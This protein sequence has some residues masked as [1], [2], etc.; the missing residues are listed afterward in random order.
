[1]R[2]RTFGILVSAALAGSIAI[3]GPAVASQQTISTKPVD[4]A[5]VGLI[6]HFKP[7]FSAN[8]W[9]GQL[10][11]QEALSAAG[12]P[13]GS[14]RAIGSGW[15]VLNFAGALTSSA[16]NRA[17]ALLAQQPGVLSVSLNRFIARPAAEDAATGTTPIAAASTS[18]ATFKGASA[19]RNVSVADAFDASSPNTPQVAVT[20]QAPKTLNGYKLTGYK[21]QSSVDA[22]VTYQ[23]LPTA[24]GAKTLKASLSSGL[25]AGGHIYLRVAAVT[26]NGKASKVGT[27][28]TWAGAVPT[29]VP[30][31]PNF[32]GP[33]VN[34]V[35]PTA[36]WDLLSV[37]DS[38]GLPVTYSAVASAAG[39]AD[40][41]CKT[42]GSSCAFTGLV[43]G[44]N[45]TVKVRAEN[46]RGVSAY[47][48][49]FTV[50]DPMYK[51]Q[52]HLNGKYG[53][54]V[55]P[56]WQHTRGSSNVTVAVIDSGITEHP[57]LSS[58]LWRNLDGSVYGYD[59]VST[60]NGS[61]DGDGWDPNPLDPSADNEWH[62]THVSGIIA[63]AANNVGIVGV[64]PGVKLLEVR[65]LGTRGGTSADLIAAL[66]WAAGKD[67]PGVPK[68]I[69]PA[70]VINLSIGNKTYSCDSGTTSVMVSLHAMNITVITAA[71]NDTSQGFYSYPGNCVPT[72]NVGATGPT[73][74]RAYYSN[75][76][77]GVDISAP[78][79]DDSK[80]GDSPAETGGEIW[81]TLN[82]GKSALGQPTYDNAEGTSMAAPMVTG[83]VALLYSIKPTI[84]VDQVWEAL[85]ST[86]T[87]WPAGSTCSTAPKDLGCGAGIANAGG[88]VEY[89]VKN[90]N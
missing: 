81:S 40:V 44:V 8:G 12:I 79:G 23:D 4:G 58:Q 85:K 75:F 30:V 3:A 84:T 73:G 66:N 76:G 6:V 27:Y 14:Q 21:L 64:A 43:P 22:G 19:V 20:W 45:Y 71:G 78:G 26:S 37:A 60:S 54:N 31:P 1:M 89:V 61:A 51:L 59:F 74:D 10:S 15:H 57:D 2:F 13:L 9:W 24:F 29:T 69:H 11:G 16:A 32:N 46:K 56:A 49:G 70:Q 36:S 52:W 67:V 42:S 65:A 39:Q 68:N 86:V 50:S 83:V 28:S 25:V 47:V 5:P 88:A 41:T 62:G 55:E 63:A 38:G 17:Q 34:S 7:G 72:I 82:D 18:V 53:I 77:Q 48:S 33:A 90:F 87:P 80:P 35:N